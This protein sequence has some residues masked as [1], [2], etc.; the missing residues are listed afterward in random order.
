MRTNLKLL[1]DNKTETE[2]KLKEARKKELD[3][4]KKE[5]ETK[6]REQELELDVQKN[7]NRKEHR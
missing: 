3:Y 6:N 4:L 5:Q 1:Q 7:Y 2:E